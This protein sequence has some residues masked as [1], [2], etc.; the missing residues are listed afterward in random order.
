MGVA[1]EIRTSG[2]VLLGASDDRGIDGYQKLLAASALAR[3]EKF[4]PDLVEAINRGGSEIVDQL[5]E[6]MLQR[7]SHR[8]TA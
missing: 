4:T 5:V 7:L 6:A 3:S 1:T 2:R 8:V